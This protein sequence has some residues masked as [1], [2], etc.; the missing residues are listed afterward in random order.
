MI[1]FIRARRLRKLTPYSAYTCFFVAVETSRTLDAYPGV[2]IVEASVVSSAPGVSEGFG[3]TYAGPAFVLDAAS[4]TVCGLGVFASN[5]L[6]YC[7]VCRGCDVIFCNVR[8]GWFRC[9][10]GMRL[11]DCML[12]YRCRIV[13]HRL[14]ERR[15]RVNER[16]Q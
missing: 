16:K 2:Q 9:K 4:D 1:H 8:R 6:S 10:N 15:I 13:P 12:C 11:T 5:C 14:R 7:F 3:Y